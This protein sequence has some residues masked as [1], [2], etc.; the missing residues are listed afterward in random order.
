MFPREK[1]NNI[2]KDQTLL[3]R[4]KKKEAA[5]HARKLMGE[6]LPGPHLIPEW[7]GEGKTR[8]QPPK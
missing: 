5:P 7:K 4:L 2:E 6:P 3:G 1:E 8:I